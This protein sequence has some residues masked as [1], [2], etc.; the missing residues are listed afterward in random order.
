MGVVS[1]GKLLP[2]P[3]IGSLGGTL[4]WLFFLAIL[5]AFLFTTGLGPVIIVAVTWGVILLV[6]YFVLS[7][8]LF[9]LKRGR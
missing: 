2:D 5:I 1:L 4:L 9:R 6:L 3:Q 7:R 8:I